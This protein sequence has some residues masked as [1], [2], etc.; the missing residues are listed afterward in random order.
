MSSLLWT[1]IV[2]HDTLWWHQTLERSRIA[3]VYYLKPEVISF[4]LLKMRSNYNS[5]ELL[6]YKFTHTCGVTI[7]LKGVVSKWQPLQSVCYASYTTGVL[8]PPYSGT[9]WE[10]WLLFIL[11][12]YIQYTCL[13]VT[14]VHQENNHPHKWWPITQASDHQS[15][16][17]IA[18]TTGFIL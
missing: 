9:P 8:N 10:L 2:V 16:Q 1:T 17:L 7:T 18:K 13:R 11:T 4:T 12:V 3:G 14:T 15:L 6:E 5:K